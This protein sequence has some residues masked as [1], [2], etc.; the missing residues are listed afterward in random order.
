MPVVLA[1][2]FALLLSPPVHALARFHI[3]PPAGAALVLLS[4]LGLLFLGGYFLAGPV[5]AWVRRTPQMIEQL[6]AKFERVARP[7]RE[8]NA[9]LRQGSQKEGLEKPAEVEIKKPSPVKGILTQT[10]AFIMTAG[11]TF[12][13][14]YFLL[15]AGDALLA[16]ILA[17]IVN[18]QRREKTMAVGHEIKGH[19]S[20]YLFALTLINAA[21]GAL[22]AAG[23]AMAGMPAPILWGALHAILN[24]IPYLG[25]LTGLALTALVSFLTFESVSHAIIPPLIYFAIMVLDNFAGPMVLGK[26]LVLNPILVFVSLMFWG[27]L[28]GIVGV[29]VA[30]PI[31]IALKIICDHLPALQRYG[32]IIS[33]DAS[34]DKI[35]PAAEESGSS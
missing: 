8:F 35:S 7:S 25:A 18:T 14:L 24:F 4:F 31:L 12:I 20:K 23:L 3:P 22:I 5:T 6:S 13:L 26:R 30:V 32:R 21:E 2:L 33:A 34:F 15:A 16:A 1:L 10:G 19:I 27:W 29:L 17:G 9:A 11:T 28:W